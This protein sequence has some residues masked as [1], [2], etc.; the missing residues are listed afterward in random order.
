MPIANSAGD[1][2]IAVTAMPP[3]RPPNGISD[4]LIAMFIELTRPISGLGMR[5]N[6]TAP[7]IGLRNPLPQPP[8]KP[9]TSTTQSG[10][11]TASA[12]NRGTPPMK[13]PTR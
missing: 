7:R 5:S 9:T 6:S 13:K 1:R 10:A 4:Q 12:T 3:S 2:P 11:P 8:T